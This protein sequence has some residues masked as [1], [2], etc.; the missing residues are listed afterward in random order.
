MKNCKVVIR[1]LP[2]I[3]LC[4]LLSM[5]VM[6]RVNAQ[7]PASSPLVINAVTSTESRC[8]ASGTVT[9]SVSGGATPYVYSI[10][11]GPTL[12]AAQSSNVLQS[13]APGTYTVQ[14]TDNC[15]TSVT[16]SV[17]VAGTYTV[18]SVTLTSQ[19]PSCGANSDGSITVNVTNGRGPF[20]YSLIA[21][22]TVTAAPQAGNV[23]T[24]LPSGSYT[25]QVTDSCGNF[26][27]RTVVVAAGTIGSVG[28]AGGSLQYLSCD[29]YSYTFILSVAASDYKPPYTATL[30][31]ADG[32]VLTQVLT[33]PGSGFIFVSFSFGYH[34]VTGANDQITITATNNCGGSLTQTS[35]PFFSLDMQP[36]SNLSSGCGGGYSYTFDQTED[37]FSFPSSIHC[38]TITY[39]LVDPAGTVLTTQ[40]N[41][42]TFS[43]YPPGSGYKVI[44][45]DCCEKDSLTFNWTAP[46]AFHITSA[47]PYSYASCKEGTAGLIMNFTNSSG[48]GQIVLASG[49]PSVTFVD[50]S[51]FTYAY[52]VTIPNLFLGGGSQVLGFFTTGTYKIYAIN[53]CGDKDS[54]MVTVSPSDLRHSTLTAIPQKG[55]AGNNAITLKAVSNTWLSFAHD[56]FISVDSLNVGSVTSAAF[57]TTLTNFPSGTYYPTYTYQTGYG[58]NAV[59]GMGGCDV[60]RDTVVIPDY[61]QPSFNPSPAVAN[62]GTIR[63]VAVL[64]DSTSGVQ[65]YQY[66]I[67]SGPATTSLQSSPVFPGLSAGTYTFLMSDACANSYSRSVT[68]DTVAV[69]NVSTTSGTCAGGAATFTLPASPFYSYAWLHPDGST[70]TG[71]TLAFNP[72]TAADTGRY[73]ITVT[74]TVGGCTSTSSK[75]VTLGFCTVLEEIL[76]HFG[77][78]WRNGYL[79]LSWRT[80]DETSIGYYV[81]ERSTSGGV[82]TPMQQVGATGLA[83]DAYTVTDTQVP[84]G[85]VDYRLQMVGKSGA[86]SYSKI[87]SFNNVNKQSLNVYPRMITGNTPV[88]VTYPGNSHTS[89]I[90]VVGID[91]RVWWTCSIPAGSTQTSIDFA[92]LARGSYFVVFSGNDSPVATQV[93][94][95]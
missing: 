40:T 24:G 43:G 38:G 36:S 91:G 54:V 60:I 8:Q 83:P 23:F 56:G 85:T 79:Q 82:F 31:L 72:I 70:S 11:A 19:A 76:L 5:T 39:T 89:F 41:N 45:Q 2:A 74:S 37:N 75:S 81:V 63:D 95:E 80:A 90:R 71:D 64:P 55:C 51:V 77:G 27:T 26:Q 47:F 13:L 68:I 14:V 20:T 32:Q 16:S 30:H 57:S 62:C 4:I 65:P 1:P 67:I 59:P 21:P 58:P 28:Y 46:P 25:C 3:L 78:E 7:C 84:S 29:T 87:L 49:P 88:R 66:Q 50:G 15:N 42:S 53:N 93:L 12:A 52:P 94:K 35:S 69:P 18:P 6:N 44:R 22:S 9:V 73:N 33:A 34:H 48:M 61:I 17:T 92:P 86:I 10:I